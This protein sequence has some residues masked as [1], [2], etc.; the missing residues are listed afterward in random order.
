VFVDVILYHKQ[1]KPK[2]N[3]VG[4]GR[5]RVGSVVVVATSV[6]VVVGSVV[7]VATSVV[8]V[9]GSVVVVVASVE[10]VVA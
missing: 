9:V 6:V 8:V 1:L 2:H 10:V 5:G 7:V 3:G 4:R